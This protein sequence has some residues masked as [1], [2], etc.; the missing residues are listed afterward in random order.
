MPMESRQSLHHLLLTCAPILL[1]LSAC[2][3]SGNTT[4]TLGADAIFTSAAQT[5]A[6]QMATQQALV[7]PTNT[8]LPLPSPFPTLP[9]PLPFA[10]ISFASPTPLTG[11]SGNCDDSAFIAD[12]TV[13]DKSKFD[14]GQKFVKTWLVQN[15]GTCPW[16]TD[17]KISFVDGLRMD[18][19]GTFVPLTVPVG[20]Q[21]EMTVNLKAPTSP[22]DYY[23]RWQLQNASSQRFGSI[24]TV[25]IKVIPLAATTP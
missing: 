18:G 1:L 11:G 4:P 13:P 15:T 9:P 12:V 10:T 6:A 5:F 24:L 17:Y 7:P 25:V 3:S 22:G 2:G 19:S 23:G 20:Q 21:T 16:T 8:P 14:P